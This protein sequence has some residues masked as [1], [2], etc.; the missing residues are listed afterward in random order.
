LWIIDDAQWLDEASS[1]TLAF[2]ARRLGAESVAMVVGIRDGARKDDFVG[3]DELVV[4]GLGERD[5][6]SLWTPS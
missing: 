6:R 3:L 2:V 1:Q 5:S 4:R